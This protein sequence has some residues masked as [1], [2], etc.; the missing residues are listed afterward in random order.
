MEISYV[1]Y[2]GSMVVWFSYTRFVEIKTRLV[3]FIIMV[4][5]YIVR[6][7]AIVDDNVILIVVFILLRSDAN[8]LHAIA[9]LEKA[10]ESIQD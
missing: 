6:S 5:A 10:C 1:S 9:I 7:D 4:Y 8:V 2:S 3:G